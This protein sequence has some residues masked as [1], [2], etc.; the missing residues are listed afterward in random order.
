MILVQEEQGKVWHDRLMLEMRILCKL[1][2]NVYVHL[3]QFILPWTFSPLSSDWQLIY[4][5]NRRRKLIQ[6][7]K[8]TW[9]NIHLRQYEQQ[10]LEFAEKY[11]TIFRQLASTL[12]QS[13]STNHASILQ[14]IQAYV[15]ARTLHIQTNV[16]N[17]VTFSRYMLLQN[18]QRS[19]VAKETVGVHPEPYLDLPSSPF[20]AQE[21]NHLCLGKDQPWL[22]LAFKS[23]PTVLLSLSLLGASFIRWNQSVIRSKDQ[24]QKVIQTEHQNIFDKVQKHLMAPPHCIP[25]T[26]R[27]FNQFGSSLQ[28]QLENVYT[29]PIHHKDRLLAHQQASLAQSIRK[30]IKEK[31]LVL[32]VVDKGS[33]FYIGSAEKLDEKAQKYFADTDAFE[34]VS[35][36]PF[37]SLMN[38]VRQKLE[39]MAK[40][41]LI[42]QWQKNK[43][44]PDPKSS[45]L[46][47]LYFNP[48]VH[49]VSR[50]LDF[51]NA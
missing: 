27:I 10:L 42:W 8:R 26:T 43:M 7:A 46:A 6:E 47:H 48:K 44:L 13:H 19:T 24:Q 11:Q 38:R 4:Y 30:K 14:T 41:K 39:A 22:R 49:K 25:R 2:P 9:L 17:Q 21:W 37:N 51:L 12:L 18:R 28:Q 15:D 32:R 35:Q 36:N 50:L 33:T 1:L 29:A 45:E 34:K 16:R 40:E 5:R 20:T 3:E 23:Y 31:Q